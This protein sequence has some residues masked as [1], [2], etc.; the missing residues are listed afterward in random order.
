MRKIIAFT[1]ILSLITIP[2]LCLAQDEFTISGRVEGLEN[3]ILSLREPNGEIFNVAA[4]NSQ[5]GGI[6]VGDSV[7]V[8]VSGGWATSIVKTGKAQMRQQT[9]HVTAT[10][11]VAAPTEIIGEVTLVGDRILKVKD[12]STQM[13]YEFTAP[14]DKLSDIKTGYRVEVRAINGRVL[15]LIRLGMPIQSESES[16]Q[17]W[18]VT[19]Y[20]E[21]VK[22][23]PLPPSTPSEERG[24]PPSATSVW[25]PSHWEWN[26]H[27]WV[28][29]HGE[30]MEPPNAGAIWEP[31]HWGW[32]G[33]EW[34]WISGHWK[35]R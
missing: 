20:P 28:W 16:S 6:E 10:T 27:E 13:E 4:K 2:S 1:T 23:P 5:L 24:I 18:S 35:E 22:R 17:R 33:H 9:K 34:V 32:N 11:V 3:G 7:V 30:W 19:K 14:P 15:S 8:R 12:D 29:V 31:S 21:E 26:G 25:I